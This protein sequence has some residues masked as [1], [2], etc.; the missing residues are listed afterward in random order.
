MK[1]DT[2]VPDCG[3]G[4]EGERGGKVLGERNVAPQVRIESGSCWLT[5]M[6][7]FPTVEVGRWAVASGRNYQPWRAGDGYRLVKRLRLGTEVG[8][9]FA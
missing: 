4:Y 8:N 3:W 6:K 1:E 7:S 5:A 9:H 2:A